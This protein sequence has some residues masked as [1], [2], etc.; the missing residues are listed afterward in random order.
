MK[1]AASPRNESNV[2]SSAPSVT[3]YATW[4]KV[5]WS[6][7]NERPLAKG[8]CGDVLRQSEC[9]GVGELDSFPQIMCEVC[10]PRS[11]YVEGGNFNLRRGGESGGGTAIE[12]AVTF[13][14]KSRKVS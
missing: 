3:G 6:R 9:S 8:S 11:L 5:G 7:E 4:M 13:E 14:R 10:E 2:V 12:N 1:W